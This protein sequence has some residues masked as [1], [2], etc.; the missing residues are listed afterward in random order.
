MHNH[1]LAVYH[2]GYRQISGLS[3][4][5]KLIVQNMSVAQVKPCAILASLLEK[6]PSDNP[7]RRQVY[8]YRDSMRRSSFEGSDVAGQFYHLTME[9]KYV[10]LTLADQDTNAL[11]RIFLAHPDCVEL[12]QHYY[13]VIGMDST[14]K[15][16][17]YRW[18]LER[19]RNLIGDDVHPAAILTDRELGLI[20]PIREVFPQTAHL[21]CTW[22]INKDVKDSVFKLY[23]RD[24][25]FAEGFKNRRWKNIIKVPTEEEYIIVLESSHLSSQD[26]EHRCLASKIPIQYMSC[27]VLHYCLDLICEEIGRM[28]ELSTDVVDRCETPISLDS[29][30][31]F[32]KR[33]VISGG[34]DTSEQAGS[35]VEPEEHRYFQGIVGDVMTQDRALVRDISLL[36]R[37]R[38]YPD[39]SCYRQ[40]EVKT[41]VKGRPPEKYTRRDPSHW[42]YSAKGCG[43]VRSRAK[44]SRGRDYS[45]PESGEHSFF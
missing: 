9:R 19:L 2:E 6:N 1:D 10:H 8:N 38:L 40:P 3:P 43:H 16:N 29:V 24:R 32:W 26:G 33:L 11:T 39:E 17:N 12:L 28:V 18:V 15:T 14:Y 20:R 36:I 44:S 22:H 45:A 25:T 34:L 13:W 30:H 23:G 41:V 31:T 21:L 4:A 5:S 7:T 27:N 37:D 42:E 35:V